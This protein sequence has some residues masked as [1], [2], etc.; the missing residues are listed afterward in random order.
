MGG[1][2]ILGAVV[3]WCGGGLELCPQPSLLDTIAHTAC[4][5][6]IAWL[7]FECAARPHG[8]TRYAHLTCSSYVFARSLATSAGQSTGCGDLLGGVVIGIVL[9][10]GTQTWRDDDLVGHVRLYMVVAFAST[11]DAVVLYGGFNARLRRSGG[12]GMFAAG[13]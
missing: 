3:R 2:N 10:V 7:V 1:D 12:S 11:I 4:W 6:A 5:V 8:R 9:D 13:S